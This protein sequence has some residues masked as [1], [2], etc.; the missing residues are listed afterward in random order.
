M[1]DVRRWMS[2]NLQ[3]VRA[4]D[5]GS[6]VVTPEVSD[7]NP[8]A[9]QQSYRSIFHGGQEPGSVSSI[10]RISSRIAT[11]IHQ[12][13]VQET[14]RVTDGS[15]RKSKYGPQL[16][17]RCIASCPSFAACSS[18]RDWSCLLFNFNGFRLRT[19]CFRP[20][21][22]LVTEGGASIRLHES[23]A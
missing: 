8:A 3:Q 20:D 22:S 7:M 9:S 15:G 14:K 19:R 13:R 1:S 12:K 2:A 6:D 4:T 5:V 16:T 11:K 10:Y 23:V 18:R 17:P 21:H